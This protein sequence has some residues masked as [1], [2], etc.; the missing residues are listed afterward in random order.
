MNAGG[1]E[2]IKVKNV[3][4]ATG[5][6]PASLPK[7]MLDIDE[8]Y[9]VSSTGA[10]ALK[11]IPKRMTVVGGGVIGLE[12]GSVYARLGTEVTVVNNTEV[13]CPFLDKE[14]AVAFQKI[15]KKQG[16]KF[17][18]GYRLVSGVNNKEK[19]VSVT[20]ADANGKEEVL[21]S[22]VTLLS[23]GRRPFTGGLNLEKAGL[24][25]T[26]QGK[27]QVNHVC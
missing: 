15:L 17:K 26:P 9:V 19:G 13:I 6:E 11:S 2:Q 18:C 21:E 16:L 27:I 12:M 5:S 22:D 10:L 25:T 3:I 20:I 7:G 14:V 4:I 23:I 24:S 1:T 8:E